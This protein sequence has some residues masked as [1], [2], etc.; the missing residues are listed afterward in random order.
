MHKIINRENVNQV[1]Q[2]EEENEIGEVN[3]FK[4][5]KSNPYFDLLK[6]L[7]RN[8]YIDETYADYM[9]YFYEN[10]LSRTDKVFLRSVSDQIAKEPTYELKEP[11]KVVEQLDEFDFD[12]EETL[13]YS[14]VDYL[15]RT[16]EKPPYLQHLIIQLKETNNVHF[17]IAYMNVAKQPVEFIRLCNT[18]W[19]DVFEKLVNGGDVSTDDLKHFAIYTLYC[20]DKNII[21]GANTNSCLSE[22]ISSTPEFLSIDSPKVDQLI[23]GFKLLGVLIKELDYS[24]AN[25]ELFNAVYTESL[26]VIS[27]ENIS[28]ILRY[29]F[30]IDNEELIRHKNFTEVR[31]SPESPLKQYISLHMEEYAE[32]ML[33]SCESKIYD[34]TEAV[35][36]FLNNSGVSEDHK[37]EYIECLKTQIP[38]LSAVKQMNLWQALMENHCIVCSEENVMVYYLSKKQIDALLVR[39]INGAERSIDFKSISELHS[40]EELYGLFK[41]IVSCDQLNNSK[42][43][44]CIVSFE[45]ELESFSVEGLSC[46]KI[47]LLIHHGVILMNSNTLVF[48][49]SNYEEAIPTYIE[50]YFDEYLSIMDARLFDSSE[51]LQVLSMDVNDDKKIRLLSLSNE[52]ISVIGKGYSSKL[53]AYI[54]RKNCDINNIRTYSGRNYRYDK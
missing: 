11:K 42:Y 40:E 25:R 45:Y 31:S 28:E 9:T 46:E 52:P 20:S 48:M 53:C 3:S 13:N 23:S 51:M 49:R 33:E 29:L 12:Q 14:L 15:I 27:F 30:C 22:Y 18:Y 38:V 2:A 21:T 16:N 34:E 35:V 39:F 7:I 36:E 32:V 19:N 37:K 43:E 4:D 44:Q 5:V 1:F 26:Y 6:F 47:E 17:I 8:G 54:L 41:A 50:T 24:I 10:S